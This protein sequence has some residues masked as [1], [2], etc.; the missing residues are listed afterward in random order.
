MTLPGNQESPVSRRSVLKAGSIVGGTVVAGGAL[1][2]VIAALSRGLTEHPSP[3]NVTAA[4]AEAPLAFGSETLPFYGARQS[5]VTTVAGTQLALLAF[6][7]DEGLGRDGARRLLRVLTEITSKLTQGQVPLADTEPE[8]VTSPARL[9]ATIGLGDGFF[10]RA[11][12]VENKPAWLRQLPAYRIDQLQDRWNGGDLV[13]SLSGDD[14]LTIAHARR[15]V[16]RAIARWARPRWVQR[17]FQGAR[18]ARPDGTTMRNL[19]GQVDGTANPTPGPDDQVIWCGPEQGVWANGTSMVVRR[20]AMNLETWDEVD[21]VARED[22]MGRTLHNGAPLTGTEEH[23][24]PD[25]EAKSPIGFPVI[26][27]Y[28]HIRRARSDNPHERIYR[29]AYNYDDDP[30]PG[31]LSN[32]GLVFVSYQA[33]PMTQYHP[34]QAR[35]AELD[36]LNEWTTPIGSAV[37]AVLPGCAD[38]EYLGERVLGL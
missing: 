7:V 2:G 31:E 33:D 16:T 10:T 20:I 26:A 18:G 23:D 3:A 21:R 13:V 27:P 35:L 6:D 15:A 17:G 37:F 22:V 28:S 4:P 8:M 32:S 25:F 9:T 14:D 36:S 12:I 29:R 38:G 5:G 30:E 1:G 19:M 34:L 11:S 24:E